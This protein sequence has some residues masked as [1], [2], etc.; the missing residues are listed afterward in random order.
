MNTEYGSL[1]YN[2]DEDPEIELNI[3]NQQYMLSLGEFRS[4][5]GF[6]SQC[7][8]VSE[9]TIKLII[10]EEIVIKA[11]TKDDTRIIKFDDYPAHADSLL[12]DFDLLLGTVDAYEEDEEL[13]IEEFIFEC[14]KLE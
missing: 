13:E 3:S 9:F 12:R 1:H 6:I 10:E 2:S 7:C 8:A 11:E 14:P 4:I 5:F